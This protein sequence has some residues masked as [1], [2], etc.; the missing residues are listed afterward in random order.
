MMPAPLPYPDELLSSAIF[1]CCR[2]FNLPFKV[3]ARKVLHMPNLRANFLSVWPLRPLERL[4]NTSAENL[5]WNHTSFPFA[6]AFLGGESFAL[7]RAAALNGGVGM[8]Q[9]LAAMQNVSSELRQRRV[10]LRCVEDDLAQHGETYWHRSHNLPGVLVCHRHGCPLAFTRLLAS[11]DLKTV[12]ALP[13]ECDTERAP[14]FPRTPAVLALA[15]SSELLLRRFPTSGETR[16]SA[17]YRDMAMRLGWLTGKREVS[18]AAVSDAIE[19]GFPSV[20]MAAAGLPADKTWPALFF[21]PGTTFNFSPLKHLIVETTLLFGNPTLGALD[22][23]SSGPPGTSS[24]AL[25]KFYAPLAR[26]ELA[27][28][29]VHGEI[30]STEQFLRRAGAYGPYRH[31]GAELPR[32]REV[33]LEF[34][35]SPASSKRL[36]PGKVL[37]RLDPAAVVPAPLRSSH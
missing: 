31:R 33:V 14:R 37:F 28:A 32:L 26:A 29:V 12:Y 34:R 3:F 15:R 36:R 1:R 10:C 30:L 17:T 24:Q 35:A 20:F 23:I 6:T 2:W 19:H 9:L 25:D 27:R 22:Y 7:A 11:A 18:Q 21:R 16:N 5:L 8:P 4:F 13:M